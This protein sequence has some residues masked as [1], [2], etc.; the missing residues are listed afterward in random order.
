MTG[1]LI[2]PV[3]PPSARRHA[4]DRARHSPA[5]LDSFVHQMAT[6]CAQ[7]V[8]ACTDP[9]EVVVSVDDGEMVDALLNHALE[10]VEQTRVGRDADHVRAGKG[11]DWGRGTLGMGQQV[12]AGDN[13][14]APP[15]GIDDGVGAV[16]GLLEPLTRAGSRRVRG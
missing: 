4:L 15:G 16:A 7:D 3:P 14:R 9:Y 6:A 5:G 8:R 1:G 10:G 12:A 2:A 11:S 13:S